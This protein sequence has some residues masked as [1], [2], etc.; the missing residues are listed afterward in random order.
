MN[1]GDDAGKPEKSF[2]SKFKKDMFPFLMD[3]CEDLIDDSV[4]CTIS[5]FMEDFLETKDVEDLQR[6]AKKF[7]KDKDSLR[8]CPKIECTYPFSLLCVCR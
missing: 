1:Q 3:H 7:W 4:Y 5:T 8:V 2:K 6:I